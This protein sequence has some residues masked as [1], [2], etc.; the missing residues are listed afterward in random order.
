MKY[1]NFLK[2]KKSW[3]N[4]GVIL[5][6][7]IMI[8]VP[9]TTSLGD[10]ETKTISDDLTYNK[11]SLEY[12][13][14]FLEPE[15]HTTEVSDSGYTN[16]DMKGCM[17]MGKLA[18]EPMMPVKSVKL[19][20]PPMKTVSNVN[21]VGN[22]VEVDLGN[23][24]LNEKPVF[25]HQDYVPIGSSEPQEFTFDN[26]IYSSDSLYPSDIY[27]D[28]RIGYSHGYAI[29]GIALN[30]MQYIPSEGKIFYYPELT[31]TIDLE[32]T[33]EVNQFFRSND[34]DKEWVESIVINPEISEYYTTYVPTFEYPGGLCDPSDNYDYVIITTTYNGLDYWDTGGSLVYNWDDLMDK[35]ESDDGLSCTLVT[36]QDIDACTDYHDPDPLFNDLEAHIREFCKDAY[37]DWGTE[38]V[39]I[40][41]DDEWIPARHMDTSYE[42]NIDSDLYWSNLDSTFNE[43]EDNYWGEAGDGGFDLYAEIFIGRLTCDEP[44]DISNWMTKSFY[45]ADSTDQDYLD[46]AAF[47]G[48]NT[49]WACEGDDFEDFS[50]IKGTD[51]WLGPYPHHDGPWP[52]WLGFLFGFETWNIVNPNN[53]YNL[54]VKWTAEPPNPGWQGGSESAA[55][56]GLKNAINNDEVALLSGIAHASASSSLDVYKSSWESDYHNTKPF[57]IHDYGCHCG[58]MDA[59][60]DGVLHSMLFHSD[61]ELAFACVYNTCYGWGNL[62]CTNSSSAL[63]QKLFWDFLLDTDNNSGDQGNWQLGKA[64]AWSKDMMAPTINWDPSYDTWRAIIQGCLL[65][66]DPAQ[67]IKTASPSD[68]PETPS[69]PNGPA[70]GIIYYDIT[71]TAST[72]DPNNDQILY[73]FDW[74]DGTNSGW[75]G[76]YNSGATASATYAW[77]DLGDFEVKVRAKDT[78]GAGSVWS[79][80]HTISIVENIPPDIPSIEGTTTGS[81]GTTYLYRFTSIDQDD[82]D[83]YFYV[84]WGD[85]NF[86]EWEGPYHSGFEAGITHTWSEE[87]TYIIRAKAMDELGDESDWATLEIAMPVNQQIT[88]YSLFQRI[89]ERF[90]NAFPILRTYLGY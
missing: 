4:L 88:I 37:E 24:D 76:P 90:P 13:F 27:E 21:I 34:N 63:Q 22:P 8:T 87:G 36:I 80:P 60:A 83:V 79:E 73:M 1:K 25:P 20:L 68:P 45:Y 40:G 81:P 65:F 9:V 2:E 84:D 39:L 70:R 43:D 49:G 72:T 61:T 6:V 67:K 38:Y 89:L 53:L 71:F 48:G 82:H 32:D 85:D 64:H 31:L 78:L 54:S 19:L 47:Y 12:T 42:T 11:N 29:F 75:L 28:Y 16:I 51:D 86:T 77:S 62:Y 56:N 66:G 7:F 30:P 44:Q 5:C 26:S 52:T 18:G 57:F 15:F 35:H 17:P 10:T 69:K 50:A 23:I 33:Q 58:D 55:I 3:R 74:G 41:G 46:N 59:A 14:V